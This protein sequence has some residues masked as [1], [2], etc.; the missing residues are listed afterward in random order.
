MCHVFFFQQFLLVCMGNEGLRQ[1]STGSCL[2]AT[3][4]EDVFGKTHGGFGD[5]SPLVRVSFAP[6]TAKSPLTFMPLKPHGALATS[7]SKEAGNSQRRMIFIVGKPL[8]SGELQVTRLDVPLL[9]LLGRC[10]SFLAAHWS[11]VCA[12][13]FF[14]EFLLVCMGN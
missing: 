3:P 6:S 13:C 7:S 9:S 1:A 14:S 2:C 10:N 11:L 12:M 8:G 5:P 4:A